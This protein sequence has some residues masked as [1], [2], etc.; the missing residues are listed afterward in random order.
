M[1]MTLREEALKLHMD[2]NGKIAVVSKV[3]IATRHDLAIAYTPGVAEPCKDIKEDKNLSFEYTCRGYMVAIITDGTR[4]L[5]LGDIGPEAAMTVMEDKAALF[6]TFGDVDAVPVCLDT[7]DPDEFIRTVKLLQPNY[8][9]VNLEDISSPKCY[10][11]EDKLKE[12][13]DIPVFHDDQHGTAI[14]CLSA[15]LGALRFVKKDIATAKFVVNGCGAAGSAI[16]RLL[17]NMGAQ[18]VIMV[19]RF[20]ALY[21][22]IDA[23][24][25]RI[26]SYLATV[27]NKEHKQGTLADVAKGADVMIGASAPNVFTK[28]IM[29]S[30]A[31]KAIVFALANPVPETSYDAAK[32]AGVAVAGTGRSDRPNQVNNV[33][34]F[35]GVFRG[36]IDVR[37]RAITEEMKVAAVYAIADLIDEKDLREDYVV[38][39]AFDPRVAP[40]VAAAVAKVAIEK[41][42][43]RKIV[44]PEVV[45]A[46]T[47]KRIGR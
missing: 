28:E 14:A 18:N 2:N 31:D 45:R 15:V 4:V 35:P 23:K 12:I 1:T 13:C 47:A 9:G 34:V 44:D 32:E 17:V 38:P 24:L 19:D 25:D 26:Q 22:G 7:K 30:M 16:G 21:E 33:T 8:A 43:A 3:P 10:E 27:T 41:G 36:A 37:A 39:D 6:K 11:I 20:G 29:Q 42:L 5:G 40:A 46:N